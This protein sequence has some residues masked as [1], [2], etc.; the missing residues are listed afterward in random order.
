MLAND[1][2]GPEHL[3]EEK[4]GVEVPEADAIEQHTPAVPTDSDDGDDALPPEI[5]DEL[6]P[7]AAEADALDQARP[8]PTQDD[9]DR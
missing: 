4:I 9:I 3:P 2:E 8:V 1:E 5:A 6:P 7:D